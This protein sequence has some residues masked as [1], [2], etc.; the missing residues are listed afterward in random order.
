[1]DGI[2]NDFANATA[3]EVYASMPPFHICTDLVQ[4]L[5]PRRGMTCEEHMAYGLAPVRGNEIFYL[6]ASQTQECCAILF[7]IRV[8]SRSICLCQS[9][10][11]LNSRRSRMT[12]V[13]YPIVDAQMIK[14]VFPG[15]LVMSSHFSQ[16]E[17]HMICLQETRSLQG[18]VAKV[19]KYW[20]VVPST[21]GPVDGDV[22]FWLQ[23]TQLWDPEDKFTFVS[24]KTHTDH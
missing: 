9:N 8:S 10:G 7:R 12:L 23:A 3:R 18:V 16:R 20:R 2:A 19:G 17:N 15:K 22:E 6:F 5:Q 11:F 14:Q 24:D 21:F 1:M 13:R 4:T